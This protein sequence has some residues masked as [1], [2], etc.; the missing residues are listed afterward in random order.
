MKSRQTTGNGPERGE[1]PQGPDLSE[2]EYEKSGMYP[3]NG[4]PFRLWALVLSLLGVMAFIAG[5]AMVLDLVL[6]Y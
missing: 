3:E 1:R 6:V 5:A 4:R 2:R